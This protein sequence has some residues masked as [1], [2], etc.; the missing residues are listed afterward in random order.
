[1]R[2]FFAL[3]VSGQ[4]A[5]Q[6]V[7]WRDKMLMPQD[8]WVPME[9]Y[10]I[11][12]AFLGEMASNRLEALSDAC[13][14]MLTSSAGL[15]EESLCIDH[16]GY[17]HKPGILWIGPGQWP[18]S[19]T[20]LNEQLVNLGAEFGARKEKRAYQPHITLARKCVMPAKPLLEPHILLPYDRVGL[21]ESQNTRKGVRYQLVESWSLP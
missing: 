7:N 15:R 11:T 18:K 10:H 12:L 3:E 17:W 19:L 1:M 5:I 6:I 16:T 2:L 13:T 20:R 9:N 21:Y 8:R 14:S 4:V